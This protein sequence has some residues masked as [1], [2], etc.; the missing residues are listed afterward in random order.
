MRNPNSYGSI[1]K[2][3]GTRR[4]PYAVRITVG[5]SGNKQV[6]KYLSY[7]PTKKEAMMALAEYNKNPFDLNVKTTTFNDVWELWKKDNWDAGAEATQKTWIAGHKNCEPIHDKPIREIKLVHLEDIMRDK[8]RSTQQHIKTVMSKVFKHA[9][10][11]ELIDKNPS[12]LITLKRAEEVEKVPF[13]LEEVQDLWKKAE[14]DEFSELIL[15]LLYTGMRIKELLILKQKDIYED[16]MIG[17]IKTKAGKNRVIPLHPAIRPFIVKRLDGQEY[18]LH[19]DKGK[20]WTYPMFHKPF[21]KRVSGHTIHETRH[22]F[23]SRMH[24][25]GVNETT[26]KFIVGHAMKDVTTKVYTH[27]FKDELVE[28]VAI[29]NYDL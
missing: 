18:L 19:D 25:L 9:L 20:P 17:G 21:L 24:T 1:V 6:R 12:S 14:T 7:H 16:H 26:I 15:I 23:I 29:L 22:T 27:K 13:T 28:K 5:W 11:H 3:S 4:K 2:L 8:G 10:K